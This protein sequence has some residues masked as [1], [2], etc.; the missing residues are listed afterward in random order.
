MPK[1]LIFVL[2]FVLSTFLQLNKIPV[3]IG[4]KIFAVFCP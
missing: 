4:R 1:E 3:G 2:N